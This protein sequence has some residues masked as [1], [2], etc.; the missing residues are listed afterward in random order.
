MGISL[1]GIIGLGVYLINETSELIDEAE[2]A[3]I[4]IGATDLGLGLAYV[5]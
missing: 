4:K 3:R 1:G 2:K 5:F